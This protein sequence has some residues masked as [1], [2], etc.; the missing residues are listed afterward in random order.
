MDNHKRISQ[1]GSLVM[2]DKQVVMHAVINADV[3]L[4][5]TDIPYC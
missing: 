2:E 5:L 1:G 3:N 4:C